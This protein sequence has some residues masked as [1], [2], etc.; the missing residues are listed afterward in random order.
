MRH[1]SGRL[2]VSYTL[3]RVTCRL[4]FLSRKL[5]PILMCEKESCVLL[6]RNSRHTARMDLSCA[7]RFDR[8]CIFFVV[9]QESIIH[10]RLHRVCI[11]FIVPHGSIIHSRLHRVAIFVIPHGSIIH[12]G[13]HRV[14]IFFLGKPHLG[15]H[16][17]LPITHNGMRYA[18]LLLRRSRIIPIRLMCRTDI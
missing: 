17:D 12:L 8:V 16:M 1:C 15:S 11:V 7:P 5:P 4:S 6:S 9:P 14:A 18:I 13:S 10:P 2:H 3:R